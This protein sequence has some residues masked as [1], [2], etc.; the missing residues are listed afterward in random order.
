MIRSAGPTR[1]EQPCLRLIRIVGNIGVNNGGNGFPQYPSLR[2]A[3]ER[4]RP[5]TGMFPCPTWPCEILAPLSER[6]PR[7]SAAIDTSDEFGPIL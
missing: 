7:N 2:H 5:R 6:I 3:R 1:P 4:L